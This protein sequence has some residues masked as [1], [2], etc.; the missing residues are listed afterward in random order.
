MRREANRHAENV[1]AGIDRD[2]PNI[3]L[4][5]LSAPEPGSGIKG[6]HTVIM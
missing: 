5:V 1:L 3:V 4:A 2:L 6:G